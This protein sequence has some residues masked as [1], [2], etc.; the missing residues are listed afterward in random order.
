[1]SAVAKKQRERYHSDEAYREKIKDINRKRYVRKTSSCVGC[2]G[3]R[4][5]E[6]NHCNVCQAYFMRIK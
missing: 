6:G 5:S 3:G 1:M 2:G 4:T